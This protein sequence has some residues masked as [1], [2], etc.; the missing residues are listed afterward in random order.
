MWRTYC[1]PRFLR[2]LF[3]YF[4]SG[5]P[6]ALTGATLS[7]WLAEAHVD[8]AAIGFFAIV[9]IPYALKFLWAPLLDSLPPPLVFRLGRRRGW[10]VVIQC[11]LALSLLLL[12]FA[13]PAL[14]PWWTGLAALLV[15]FASASQDVVI[16]AYRVE[17]LPASEQG[18]GAAIAQ[19]GYRLGMI[20][21]GA[22]ALY[23]ATYIGWQGTY[24]IM[25]AL[26]GVGMAAILASGEPSAAPPAFRPQFADW[27]KQSVIAPFA[28]FTRHRQWV[29][30]LV[31]IVLFSLADA[32]LGRMLNPFLYQAGFS[33][34]EV[35]NIV[36]MYGVVATL[37]GTFI[38]GS[39][40]HRFGALRVLFAA[41]MLHALTNL[42]YALQAYVGHD[43]TLLALGTTLE[44]VTGGISSAAFVAYLSSLCNLHYTATQY[45]LL[46]ALASL[47][48]TLLSGF[49]GEIVKRMGWMGFFVFSATL[50]LPGLIVLGVLNKKLRATSLPAEATS[51]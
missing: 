22:G 26:V 6:L 50:A 44:N 40:V 10:I 14:H 18:E 27:I 3:L 7:F 4:A 21:S 29:L 46:S 20:A 51:G 49:A 16:D 24:C 35:A 39:L 9:G 2:L 38:G 30:I 41:A 5:L 43:V 34:T 32:F 17:I 25:A 31:F 23:L 19:L 13:D 33:K 12:G 36:K 8:I 11:F 48:R 1:T 37:L 45:A 15:A 42:M 47:G 28:D